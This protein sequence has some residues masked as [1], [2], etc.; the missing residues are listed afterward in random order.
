MSLKKQFADVRKELHEAASLVG[1]DLDE[2]GDAL[3]TS[4]NRI[5]NKNYPEYE[6]DDAGAK[7]L[8]DRFGDTQAGIEVLRSLA[9]AYGYSFGGKCPIDLADGNDPWLNSESRTLCSFAM[10]TGGAIVRCVIYSKGGSGKFES[11]LFRF[12]GQHGAK[13]RHEPMAKLKKWALE[14][15][16]SGKYPSANAAAFEIKEEVLAY[17][18][19]IGANLT[20]PNAQRTIADWIRK[21]V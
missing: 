13:I 6:L 18:R 15:Y 7:K 21:S 17:G 19:T 14:K 2:S 16:K 20:P 10:F 4:L 12:M 3:L 1:I 11:G 5:N 9:M 8:L